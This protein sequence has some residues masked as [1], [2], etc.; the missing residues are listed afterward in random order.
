MNVLTFNFIPFEALLWWEFIGILITRLGYIL[1]TS[2]FVNDEQ[3][4]RNHKIL[5]II[6]I[7]RGESSLKSDMKGKDLD[8]TVDN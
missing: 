4:L 2:K 1:Y 5:E 7:G 6:K 3:N 8:W